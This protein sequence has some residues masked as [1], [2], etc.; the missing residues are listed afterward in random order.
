[1]SRFVTSVSNSIEEECHA[2]IL[3]DNMDISRLIVYAQQVE[4]TSLRKKNREVKRARTDDRNSYKG[5]FEGQGRSRFRKRFSNQGSSSAPRVNKDR[6]SN[7][8]PQGGTS[9]G[10]S[11]VRP[12][13]A[14]CGKKHD[15]KCLVGIGVCYCC[16]KSGHQLKD[17]PTRTAKGRDDKQTPPSGSNSDAPKKKHFYAL[18]SR[19]DQESSPNVMTVKFQFRNESTLEWMGGNSMHRGQ[20]VSSLKARKIISKGCFYHIVR[21]MDVEFE[22]PSLELVPVVSKFPK[23]FPNDLPGIPPE[24]EIDFGID[25]MPDMQPISIS[26]YRMSSAELKELKDQLKDLL[27]KGFIQQVKKKDR[28]LIMCIDYRQLNKV[29]MNNKSVAFLGHIVS[30]KGIEV[31]P[32]MMDAVKGCPRPLTP[33]NIRSFLGLAGYYRRFVEGFSSIDSPLTAL[34]QKKAKF[35]WS[36][37]CEKSFQELKDRLTYALVLTLLKVPAALWCIV[38]LLE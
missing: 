32:K 38:M 25:L 6:V 7:L 9:G 16:G 34:T 4:E 12:T 37:A 28:S 33:T 29:T 24:R 17:C 21:V 15:G 10:S 36:E 35:V 22:T 20:F 1:M 2:A 11:M 5:K 23:V 3:H 26:P 14:K 31:D 8:K 30:S 18:Q 27:D 13:C 19:G